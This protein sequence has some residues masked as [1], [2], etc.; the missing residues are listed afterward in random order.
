MVQGTVIKY[1]LFWFRGHSSMC[2]KYLFYVSIM[3]WLLLNVDV[4]SYG[5][6]LF[7][8]LSNEHS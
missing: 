4:N 1:G 8:D 2:F 7:I 5:P 3:S 6:F